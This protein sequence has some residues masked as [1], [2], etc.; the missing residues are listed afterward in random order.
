MPATPNPLGHSEQPVRPSPAQGGSGQSS[1]PPGPVPADEHDRRG[2][3]RPQRNVRDILPNESSLMGYPGVA[4]PPSMA[5]PAGGGQA[6]SG[7]AA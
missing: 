7:R 6:R 1:G 3:Q 2:G 5:G 4:N